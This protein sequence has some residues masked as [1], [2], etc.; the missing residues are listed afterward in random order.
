MN[1]EQALPEKMRH[2]LIYSGLLVLLVLLFILD[3]CHGAVS[4][5][6]KEVISVLT[7]DSTDQSHQF[8]VMDFRLPKAITA[9][10]AGGAIAVSG[11]VMQTFFRNP[12]AGPFVLGISSGASLGVA[13]LVMAGSF[14]GSLLAFGQWAIIIASL[15]GSAGVLILVI[16]ASTK[17]NDSVSLLI[18]GLMFGSFTSAV[19][20][21]L[22]FFSLPELVQSYLFWTFGSLS[23]V[24]WAQLAYLVPGVAIG[25]IISF[26]LQKNLNLL[27]LGENYALSLGM[28]LKRNRLLIIIATCLLAGMVTAFC[29]PV[30]F[31][32]LAVPHL[33]RNLMNTA[34]HGKLIPAT[35]LLG[36]VLLILCD[37]MTQV[38]G[39]DLTL[40][41][42]ALTSL[43]GAPVVVAI[44]VKRNRTNF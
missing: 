44:I 17:V 2:G 21:V 38:P 40:P 12:L 24:G 6:F 19:V 37:I 8:I 14:F 3:I 30:A 33:A 1:A 34:D 31:L 29:G 5:S 23:G 32:G 43:I 11:L 41:I 9:L 13:L 18:I 39:Q 4:L 35:A 20:S 36:S 7:G 10:V 42:N 22:E 15:V 25:L 28:N 16:G 26:A 27:L